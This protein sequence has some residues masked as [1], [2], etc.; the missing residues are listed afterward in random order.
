V[1]DV[2]ARS[3]RVT[4]YV[5]GVFFRAWTAE[6]ARALD[7]VGWVCN[8]PDGSVEGHLEGEA[9]DV[10]KLIGRLHQGPPSAQVV[11]VSVE[12][13]APQGSDRFEVRH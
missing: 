5:Q 3:V 4:G 1:A 12:E 8:A 13:A 9:G 10:Q 11:Q 7:V 6:Q 2:I